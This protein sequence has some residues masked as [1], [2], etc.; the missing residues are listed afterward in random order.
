MSK[1]NVNGEYELTE[2]GNRFLLSQTKIENAGVD[3][4]VLI[5][6]SDVGLKVL[7]ESKR[8]HS[9]GT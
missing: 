9:D 5:F 8:W 7:A 2:C 3:E 4:H 1:L 6:C